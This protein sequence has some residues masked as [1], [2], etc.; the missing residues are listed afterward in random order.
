M[1]KQKLYIARNVEAAV[2][3]TMATADISVISTPK[4]EPSANIEEK[5]AALQSEFDLLNKSLTEI[6]STLKY[7]YLSC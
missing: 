4:S 1:K 5:L 3:S 6:K 2:C 7:N